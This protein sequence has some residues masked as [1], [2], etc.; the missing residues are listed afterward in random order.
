MTNKN[1]KRLDDPASLSSLQLSPML[2][3]VVHYSG[4]RW[5]YSSRLDAGD[6]VSAIHQALLRL[7]CVCT[8]SCELVESH[9]GTSSSSLQSQMQI[10]S[11]SKPTNSPGS[12]SSGF[13][14]PDV[15][16]P[17]VWRQQDMH[18]LLHYLSLPVPIP[19]SSPFLPVCNLLTGLWDA[20]AQTFKVVIHTLVTETWGLCSILVTQTCAYP[21]TSSICQWN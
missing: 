17:Q 5:L 6:K 14:K 13:L 10:Q 2:C 1:L 20:Q 3:L 9:D 15:I 11:I 12:Q 18:C 4:A 8:R 19:N 7:C 16:F 21:S